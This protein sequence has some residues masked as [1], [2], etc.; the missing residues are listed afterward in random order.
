MRHIKL[1][2]GDLVFP[3]KGRSP[4]NPDPN[5]YVVDRYDPFLFHLK[6]P[7][8]DEREI[9]QAALPRCNKIIDVTYCKVDGQPTDFLKCAMCPHGKVV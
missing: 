7:D 4:D 1:D 6:L 3:R 2:N 5:K 8:C 9:R